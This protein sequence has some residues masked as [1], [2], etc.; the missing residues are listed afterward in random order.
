MTTNPFADP[1]NMPDVFGGVALLAVMD[2]GEFLCEKC[3]TDSNNPVHD[4]RG[5]SDPER[6]GWGVVALIGSND[7]E[8]AANCAH[9]GNVIVDAD[10]ADDGD[11]QDG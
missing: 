5:K 8:E 11:E 9:C 10:D 3:L 6:D 1:S 4:E 2:D 7:I